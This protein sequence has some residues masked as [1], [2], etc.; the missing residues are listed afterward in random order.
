MRQSPLQT[1]AIVLGALL[2][3]ASGCQMAGRPADSQ[4]VR[5]KKDPATK[6]PT[7]E[8]AL[9]VQ[10]A[11]ARTMEQQ[12]ESDQ[13]TSIYQNIIQR[14]PKCGPAVHRLAIVY[15]QAKRFDE[16][17]PLFKQALKLQPGNAEIYCDLGYSE[18]LQRRW[19]E[20]EAN[21]RQAIQLQPEFLRAHNHLGMLL[22]R[23]DRRD[24]GIA[25]F[26]RAGC[27]Q[28][29]AHIN[30]AVAL[31]F[32]DRPAEARE[33]YELARQSGPLPKEL[34]GRVAQLERLL[35][36]RA[37]D[38]EASPGV[39]RLTSAERQEVEPP[40]SKQRISRR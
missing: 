7:P 22:A 13:A 31:I 24:E 37:A 17:G 8:Q 33:E 19:A 36:E 2:T 6:P 16:S 30:C 4:T 20:S 5:T 12:H 18:Y 26:R 40:V 32:N 15:D 10:L 21:L 38:P 3:L 29:Q 23:T 1:I 28:T 25:E 34:E 14:H 35:P 11:L 9:D 27:T 39:I